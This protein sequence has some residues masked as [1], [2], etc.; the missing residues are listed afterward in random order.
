MWYKP[1]NSCLLCLR[2]L[3]SYRKMKANEWFKHKI[4]SASELPLHPSFGEE[5]LDYISTTWL[6]PSLKLQAS[7]CS[8]LE[9]SNF[10]LQRAW[11][12]VLATKIRSL[13]DSIELV[14]TARHATLGNHRDAYS[15]ISITSAPPSFVK[16]RPCTDIQYLCWFN[17]SYSEIVKVGSTG[18]IVF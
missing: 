6:W 12:I 16:N 8:K 17:N 1:Q 5:R 9:A 10:K 13:P 14:C 2:S 11:Y 4:R 3:K 7:S 18:L 15:W